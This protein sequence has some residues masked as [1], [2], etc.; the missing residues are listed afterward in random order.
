MELLLA[1]GF[2]IAADAV[3]QA[4]NYSDAVDRASEDLGYTFVGEMEKLID[5]EGQ[6]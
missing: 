6:R 5:S 1:R 3:E 4:D 2:L